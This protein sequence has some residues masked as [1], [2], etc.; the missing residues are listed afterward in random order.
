MPPT[1]AS[2][3]S[4]A[5]SQPRRGFCAER[6]HSTSPTAS[7]SN[8]LAYNDKNATSFPANRGPRGAGAFEST[9]SCWPACKVKK[10]AGRRAGPFYPSHGVR[11]LRRRR[12]PMNC[13]NIKD[14]PDLPPDHPRR[15]LMIAHGR[16]AV[17]PAAL[18]GMKLI[19][20]AAYGDHAVRLI[21]LPSGVGHAIRRLW[22]EIYDAFADCTVDGS[23]CNDISEALAAAEELLAEAKRLNARASLRPAAGPKPVRE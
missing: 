5:L 13:T 22:V 6:R 14:L 11:P 9:C 23:G 10:T 17:R 3:T 2:A 21:E 12:A 16:L 4:P 15:L 18:N 19:P 7:F 20:I 8:D 1:L